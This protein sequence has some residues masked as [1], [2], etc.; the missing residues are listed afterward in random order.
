M[1]WSERSRFSVLREDTCWLKWE[2]KS[3]WSS[4]AT[5][6]CM[7]ARLPSEC[8]KL[9]RLSRK[10]QKCRY[11]S[12]RLNRAAESFK[13]TWKTSNTRSKKWNDGTSRI[14]SQNKKHTRARWNI[15]R[16]QSKS[17][18]TSW[19]AFSQL[20]K[21]DWLLQNKLLLVIFLSF[22]NYTCY[23]KNNKNKWTWHPS[24]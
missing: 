9:Y 8:A 13:T 12:A 4:R 2:M 1:S 15:W 5:R 11:R 24:S 7:R 18:R 3:R 23:S 21:S 20:L 16:K 19:S 10:R 22:K 14:A 6:L 17:W